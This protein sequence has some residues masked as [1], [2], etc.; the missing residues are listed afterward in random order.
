MTTTLSA[1]SVRDRIL[2]RFSQSIGKGR[3]LRYFGDA[4]VVEHTTDDVCVTT[5]NSFL[6]DLL[7]RRFA[8]DLR[9]AITDELRESD[10]SVRIEIDPGAFEQPRTLEPGRSPD[11]SGAQG[12]TEAT[13]HRSGWGKDSVAVPP[14]ATDSPSP[15]RHP[16]RRSKKG[17]ARTLMR[18]RRLEDFVVGSSNRLAYHA[19]TKLIEPPTISVG[20]NVLFIHGECGLGKTHLLQGLV[21]RMREARPGA[22]VRYT[23]GEA[24]T[25]AFVH[26]VCNN[27]LNEF[28]QANRKLDLLCID[29]VHFLSR[30]NATQA[31][32][33]HTFDAMGLDGARVALASDEH[34]SRIRDLSK[35]LISRFVAGMIVEL[36]APDAQTRIEIARLLASR[37][38]LPVDEEGLRAIG[39]RCSDSVREI[40]GA[41]T[42]LDALRRFTPE[43]RERVV[44]RSIVERALGVASASRPMK[45]I[46][47]EAIAHHVCQTLS[48]D[49]SDVLGRS[50]HKRVVLARSLTAYLTRELTTLSFPEIARAMG[51]PNH[52]TIV[53]A[54]RRVQNQITCGAACD[55]G[56]D[57]E[58]VSVSDLARRMQRDIVRAAEPA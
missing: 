34:P 54:H 38:N 10:I 11:A 23:T 15:G 57:L 5:A 22:R 27:K 21:Q 31:E 13:P 43:L 42:Q 45:P 19:A 29:D 46:R 20:F 51:R 17:T 47:A 50:R 58:G 2:D 37:Q 12:A 39:S 44:T 3:F 6:A 35:E 52:S 18:L 8:S 30:K 53:T 32:F 28:Q 41:I 26:A 16:H 49:I 48:V 56:P 40:E 33:L 14:P 24:F 36:V 4:L 7:G 1:L 55:S 9:Q 25:N